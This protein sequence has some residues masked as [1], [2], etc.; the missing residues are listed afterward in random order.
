M[1]L[2]GLAD[3]QLHSRLA[4]GQRF[5]V[6][7]DMQAGFELEPLV[8]GKAG[9]VMQVRGAR[10]LRLQDE[11]ALAAAELAEVIIV[12][13]P[14]VFV[15]ADILRYVFKRDG[16][17]IADI[18]GWELLAVV[19]LDR[20]AAVAGGG[21][22]QLR[23]ADGDP[24]H[25]DRLLAD[26][27]VL[28]RSQT[29]IDVRAALAAVVDA[30][31]LIGR[32]EVLLAIDL[33][34]GAVQVVEHPQGFIAQAG[35]E[36]VAPGFALRRSIEEDMII[37]EGKLSAVKGRDRGVDVDEGIIRG[38]HAALGVK[39][40]GVYAGQT[41]REGFD[42]AILLI[43]GDDAFILA[44]ENQLQL[45][46]LGIGGE[47]V[48]D[49]N[50]VGEGE[51]IIERMDVADSE[52][53]VAP[54]VCDVRDALRTL[55]VA[56]E[57]HGFTVREG[58]FAEDDVLVAAGVVVGGDQ[59]VFVDGNG[60]VVRAAPDDADRFL[61]RGQ[62]KLEG[63]GAAEREV[64]A[65]EG[66][67]RLI[68]GD[69]DHRFG[70]DDHA[71]KVRVIDDLRGA[72]GKAGDQTG[73]T[74]DADDLSV[75]GVETEVLAVDLQ[76]LGQG[77]LQ[78]GALAGAQ[79]QLRRLHGR[80][81]AENFDG[82]AGFA[83]DA[84]GFDREDQL[85]P[86]GA[87]RA[88]GAGLIDGEDGFVRAGKALAVD[89]GIAVEP[90]ADVALIARFKVHI[91]GVQICLDVR[92]VDG[93]DEGIGDDRA[94]EDGVLD[95]DE[96]VGGV[97]D[98]RGARITRA[99][100]RRHEAL[101]HMDVFEGDDVLVVALSGDDEALD[102]MAP[103]VPVQLGDD[104]A[105]ARVI[106]P[107]GDQ[108]IAVIGFA[109]GEPLEDMHRDIGGGGRAVGVGDG[110]GDQ[111]VAG[112]IADDGGRAKDGFAGIVDI[113]AAGLLD[114]HEAAVSRKGDGRALRQLLRQVQVVLDAGVGEQRLLVEG[115]SR[116]GD[117]DRERRGR[118]H[119]VITAHRRQGR[120]GGD[121]C[122][123]L[124]G[125]HEH[126]RAVYIVHLDDGGIGGFEREL[127]PG[128][129][130]RNVDGVIGIVILADVEVDDV[131][132]HFKDHGRLDDGHLGHA[133]ISRHT[134]F[135][136]G[137]LA[138]D[139]GDDDGGHRGLARGKRGDHALF[140]ADDGIVGDIPV[141]EVL[142]LRN[143][144][145][146]RADGVLREQGQERHVHVD[147]NGRIRK[148]LFRQEGLDGHVIEADL[149][150]RPAEALAVKER[151]RGFR[152]GDG[153]HVIQIG[154]RITA[155]HRQRHAVHG[156]RDDDIAA[157]RVRRAEDQ[158]ER[159]VPVDIISKPVLIDQVHHF[160][161]CEA[162]RL[163]VSL[164]RG[165]GR[166][167]ENL[168]AVKGTVCQRG[169]RALDRGV[170]RIAAA[171]DAAADLADRLGQPQ[172]V[173]VGVGKRA[174]ANAFHAAGQGHFA[175][176]Q[177]VSG[178]RFLFDAGQVRGQGIRRLRA[179]NR[180]HQKKQTQKQNKSLFHGG[181][182]SLSIIYTQKLCINDCG[183][184]SY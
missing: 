57:A 175:G 49:L 145:E 1:E 41:R 59:A 33:L 80:G 77:D 144:E 102:I 182:A 30:A 94:R 115:Q 159:T 142:V 97:G 5:L 139:S 23:R 116:I 12:V 67:A 29:R 101:V 60:A 161:E 69:G 75:M 110:T 165:V 18:D 74:V 86:A 149:G 168:H 58:H 65:V 177:R 178:K 91:V 61:G 148:R 99:G 150:V 36:E 62:L 48:D 127:R 176:K 85:R 16:D 183:N 121:G 13:I 22:A 71:V 73:R 43:D 76:A 93:D 63:F 143:I 8:A 130:T 72:G 55:D 4:E 9:A 28:V 118:G 82:R 133:V 105:I 27:V 35:M 2:D 64:R 124:A 88:D 122:G 66:G 31:V 179:A 17:D 109:P 46:L 19:Q 84:V 152:Q 44:D 123:A 21:E 114:G 120:C 157:V 162:I 167:D 98:V 136:G 78:R 134:V 11:R 147:L 92:I 96:Q 155:D 154:E 158:L 79:R 32:Q 51:E 129:L 140:N 164:R 38:D 174:V 173:D 128:D 26:D 34:H 163:G 171:E 7:L 47:F 53:V 10:V 156:G 39:E 45:G 24:N 14:I 146:L 95:R 151:L 184:I 117:V 125:G 20:L 135:I 141:P 25:A 180:E 70:I 83:E 56:L 113:L 40:L 138:V 131:L 3:R 103:D 119:G 160:D 37:L 111:A 50:A 15:V 166:A 169:I 81:V 54:H 100:K 172:A 106:F 153:G 126:H 181:T 90:V 132:I 68:V 52:G 87:D 170:K 6:A 107:A 137:R 108:V 104:I 89:V 112:L 42:R